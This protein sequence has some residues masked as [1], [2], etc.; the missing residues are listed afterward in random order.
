MGYGS[1]RNSYGP[2]GYI[3]NGADDNASGVAAL[4]EV[5]E[6]ISK[7]PQKP[8]RTILFR[9]LGRRREGLWGSEYG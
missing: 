7:L 2:I 8:K 1:F 3:H 5:A 6:A 9:I 4:L